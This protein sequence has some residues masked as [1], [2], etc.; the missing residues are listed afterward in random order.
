MEELYLPEEL[1]QE[2]IMKKSIN[3]ILEM[4]KLSKEWRDRIDSLWCRLLNR[5]FKI[6][7]KDNCYN[8]YK[9]NYTLKTHLTIEDDEI[10]KRFKKFREMNEK[11][12]YDVIKDVGFEYYEGFWYW[13]P[14]TQFER[15]EKDDVI[16]LFK[17]ETKAWNEPSLYLYDNIFAIISAT[18]VGKIRPSGINY[19][20]NSE[21]YKVRTLIMDDYTYKALYIKKYGKPSY[22]HDFNIF[23]RLE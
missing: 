11:I 2:I 17:I 15:H 12:F 16:T 19:T 13:N 8:E 10:R 5:D 14:K 18:T 6:N 21:Y 9:R 4:R 3:E 20:K 7:K 1:W 23:K 22:Y